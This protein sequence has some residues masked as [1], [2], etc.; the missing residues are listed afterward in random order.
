MNNLLVKAALLNKRAGIYSRIVSRDYDLILAN[1]VS[2][3]ISMLADDL[4]LSEDVINKSSLNSAIRRCKVKAK[5]TPRSI[6]SVKAS[7][8]DRGFKND[9]E[10]DIPKNG[11]SFK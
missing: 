9:F 4:N 6:S 5:P 1:T 10:K 2:F 3:Y 11:I 7:D 8:T